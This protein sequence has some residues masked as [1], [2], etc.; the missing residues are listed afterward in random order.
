MMA[1]PHH[2]DMLPAGSTSNITKY[3]VMKGTMSEVKVKRWVMTEN[4]PQYTWNPQQGT[5]TNVPLN[6]CDSIK[7][8]AL[9]DT[10]YFMPQNQWTMFTAQ[11]KLLQSRDVLLLSAM[12]Y[13]IEIMYVMPQC[14]LR[15]QT[16]EHC[17][18]QILQNG[19]TETALQ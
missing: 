4:L 3:Q 19:L 11:E 5:L 12:N 13:M 8:Y 2:V 7:K 6:W 1:L 17:L 16:T 9:M 15:Q 18:H 14:R 10:V